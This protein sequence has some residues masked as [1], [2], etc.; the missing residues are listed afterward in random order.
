MSK[1]PLQFDKVINEGASAFFEASLEDENGAPVGS[2]AIQSVTMNYYH[3]ATGAIINNRSNQNVL[4]AN[5]VT[6]SPT[7]ALVWELDEADTSI[8]SAVNGYDEHRAE[9]KVV[10]GPDNRRM[11]FDVAIYVRDFKFVG[12]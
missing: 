10:W 2:A 9:F 5:G 11:N 6:I 12:S 4:N 8:V 3:L 1:D 7:G